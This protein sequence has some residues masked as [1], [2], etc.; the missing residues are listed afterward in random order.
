MRTMLIKESNGQAG[1]MMNQETDMKFLNS[2]LIQ[3]GGGC[4]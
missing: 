1:K 2:F 4:H 3:E